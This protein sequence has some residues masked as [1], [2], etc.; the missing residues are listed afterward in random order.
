M[1][2]YA[3]FRYMKPTRTYEHVRG[4]S[5]SH[6]W[7]DEHHTRATLYLLWLLR[8]TPWVWVFAWL[9]LVWYFWT[10]RRE[11]RTERIWD[12]FTRN[13]AEKIAE[14]LDIPKAQG[15]P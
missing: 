4:W 8:W 13:E 11:K 3:G 2:E 5:V 1:Y 6:D 14:W 9:D 15:L 12:E 7:I 10:D